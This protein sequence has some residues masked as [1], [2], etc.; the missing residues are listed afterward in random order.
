MQLGFLRDRVRTEDGALVPWLSPAGRP[1][2]IAAAYARWGWSDLVYA[3]APNGAC[4]T[5]WPLRATRASTR[6]GS[7]SSRSS[8]PSTSAAWR[9]GPSPPG[10]D[11]T[12]DLGEQHD[13]LDAGEPPSAALV[14][15][16]RQTYTYR[17]AYSLA[18]DR[19]LPAPLLI[20]NGRTD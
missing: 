1:L 7:T 15:A 6:S 14:A 18:S 20:E 4:L 10:A 13:L 16:S 2:S 5:A 9:P 8:P 17:S 12:A 19:H 3:L 11:P